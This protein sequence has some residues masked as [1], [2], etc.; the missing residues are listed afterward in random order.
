M[1]GRRLRILRQEGALRVQLVKA[2]GYANVG[3]KLKKDVGDL[4]RR[5]DRLYEASKGWSSRKQDTMSWHLLEWVAKSLYCL[6]T[7]LDLIENIDEYIQKSAQEVLPWQQVF[8]I[9][10]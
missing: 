6:K 10:E 7:E 8:I 3:D 1:H 5:W 4:Q 9:P 2:G